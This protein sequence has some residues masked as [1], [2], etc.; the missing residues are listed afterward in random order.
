MAQWLYRV[1]FGHRRRRLSLTPFARGPISG[2]APRDRRSRGSERPPAPFPGGPISEG[3]GG[4]EMGPL[5]GDVSPKQFIANG[6]APVCGG[7]N[8]HGLF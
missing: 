3:N 7:F 8:I 2:F 4:S 6:P 1:T 5:G